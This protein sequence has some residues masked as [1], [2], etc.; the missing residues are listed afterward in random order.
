MIVNLENLEK[1]LVANWTQ[2]T[3][4]R[5]LREFVQNEVP[6]HLNSFINVPLRKGSVN[7][8][9]LSLSKFQQL[10][11][12]YSLW[13]EFILPFG[14]KVI[15]GTIEALVTLEGTTIKLVSINGS[16]G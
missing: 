1:T 7:T 6:K 12:G 13:I 15:E 2:F 14:D 5:L 4:I 10:K 16:I 9:S 8:N 3:D 11:N